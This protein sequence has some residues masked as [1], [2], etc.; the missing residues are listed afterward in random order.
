MRWELIASPEHMLQ[1][2]NAK[3]APTGHFRIKTMPR[4]VH[5]AIDVLVDTTRLLSLVQAI[6]TR[7]VL[8]SPATIT[9]HPYRSV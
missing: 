9:V 1:I 8:A 4:N 3:N 5:R 7:I 2:L 6:P